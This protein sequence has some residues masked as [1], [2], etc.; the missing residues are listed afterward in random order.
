MKAVVKAGG[1]Q[2]LVSVGDKVW[3]ELQKDAKVGDEIVLGETLLVSEGD[4]VKVGT[5]VLEGAKVKAKVLSEEKGDKTRAVF[6]R[7]R[8]DS[9]TTKG[10]RQKYHAVEIVSIEG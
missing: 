5:P 2:T 1:K 3:V 10:H 6:F 4:S 8:S 9:M 7:R